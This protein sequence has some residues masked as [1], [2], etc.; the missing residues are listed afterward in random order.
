MS[1]MPE[2]TSTLPPTGEEHPAATTKT[3]EG[4]ATLYKPVLAA[5]RDLSHRF[6]REHISKALLLIEIE[7]L[8]QKELNKIRDDIDK[9]VKPWDLDRYHRSV[10][11]TSSWTAVPDTPDAFFSRHAGTK[12]RLI[13]RLAGKAIIPKV[14]KLLSTPWLCLELISKLNDLALHE[15][16]QGYIDRWDTRDI[17]PEVAEQAQKRAQ[18]RENSQK[19]R[20]R[21]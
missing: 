4:E 7:D 14:N 16:I 15:Q 13:L 1:V 3:L 10:L 8:A 11:L 17:E 19:K 9:R 6:P 5:T 12:P 20:Q 21:G 2:N 18:K